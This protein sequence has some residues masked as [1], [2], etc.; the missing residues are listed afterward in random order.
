MPFMAAEHHQ[1]LNEIKTT[2]KRCG[3]ALRPIKTYTV[4][5]II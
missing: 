5:S 1:K 3:F 2:S 4:A